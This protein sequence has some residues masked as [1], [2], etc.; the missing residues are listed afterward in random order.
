MHVP[1]RDPERLAA[2]VSSLLRD[3]E[4][5]AAYGRAGVQRARRLY[6]WNRIA[7]ATLDV[8]AR[9]ERRRPRRARDG[10]VARF[11]LPP[12]P[13]EHVHALADALPRIEGELERLS[14]LGERLAARLLDG[15][16]LLAAG[17]GGSAAQ[18]QHLTAELVGRYQSERPPLSAICLHGDSSSLT[19]IANDYGPEQAFARQVLA[20]GRRDDVLVAL[21][22][23]G[24]SKNVLAAARAAREA[25]LQ[26]WA[27][28]GPVPN[29]LADLCDEVVAFA[30]PSAATVQELHMV[31]LHVMCAAVD[32][33]VALRRNAPPLE[34]TLV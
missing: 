32:R 13:A 23:S 34:E 3:H 17:N 33:E 29:P 19:A 2:A 9:L 30:C 11:A 12:T 1:Q 7:A 27:F 8:Y 20:H 15:G 25:G 26:A 16:R 14:T 18:A 24:R 21:S 22:T 5:R 28:T 6:D 31:A 10:S 4:R